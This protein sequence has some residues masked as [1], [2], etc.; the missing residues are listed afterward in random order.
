VK[1]GV[2]YVVHN[3]VIRKPGQKCCKGG[4]IMTA[5]AVD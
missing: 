5:V 4:K 2:R 1:T 3:E